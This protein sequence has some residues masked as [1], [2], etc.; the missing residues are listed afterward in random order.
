MMTLASAARSV[1]LS[2]TVRCDGF[3][4]DRL[5][6]RAP[7]E[8]DLR[9]APPAMTDEDVCRLIVA[10]ICRV[11][12]DVVRALTPGDEARVLDL[13]EPMLWPASRGAA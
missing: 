9:P 11:P 7:T 1:R 10:R 12:F 2:T 3:V 8:N 4:Y 5:F 6:V 13:V